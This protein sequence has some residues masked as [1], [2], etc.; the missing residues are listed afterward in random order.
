[1]PDN[2]LQFIQSKGYFSY[3]IEDGGI[4][5][6]K[7]EN[8]AEAEK[9]VRKAYNTHSYLSDDACVDISNIEDAWFE[10]EPDIIEI[11]EF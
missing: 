1:M 9:K 5:I 4:G 8:K 2:I 6:V 3:R 11:A 7:A 10:D